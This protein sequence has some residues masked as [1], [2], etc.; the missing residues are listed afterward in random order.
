MRFTLFIIRIMRGAF[1]D[2]LG[3]NTTYISYIYGYLAYWTRSRKA[4]TST[5]INKVLHGSAIVHVRLWALY[6]RTVDNIEYVCISDWVR[7]K[8]KWA[9]V[10]HIFSCPMCFIYSRF[11]S[12]LK[13]LPKHQH[14]LSRLWVWYFVAAVNFAIVCVCSY[15]TSVCAWLCVCV[16]STGLQ[17]CLYEIFQSH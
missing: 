10:I 5:A 8:R 2:S 3:H 13:K 9:T 17:Y 6:T 12:V 16:R 11:H 15:S 4:H 14:E 1:S 7:I